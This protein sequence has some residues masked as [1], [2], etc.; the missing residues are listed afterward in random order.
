MQNSF[1]FVLILISISHDWIFK[2]A[3]V[4]NDNIEFDK[5]DLYHDITSMA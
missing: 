5:I 3:I 4:L 1:H 2:T